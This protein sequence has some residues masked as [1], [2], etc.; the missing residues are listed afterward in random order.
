ME[1]SDY[2]GPERRNISN[3]TAMETRLLAHIDE[4]IDR[5]EE[6]LRGHVSDAF[7]ASD[8]HGHRLY[9]ESVMR[10]VDSARRIRE[11]LAL[12]VVKGGL[13]ILALFLLAGLVEYLRRAVA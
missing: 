6:A 3:E 4:R 1:S 7:P 9:H 13:T 5:I 12:W 8:V 2:K 11:D 10:S